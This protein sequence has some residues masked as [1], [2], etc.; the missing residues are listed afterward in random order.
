MEA[1]RKRQA[2]L[3][4]LL[5]ALAG[6]C[7][8]GCAE[9]AGLNPYYRRQWAEDERFGPTYHT[10]L[11]QIR[12]IEGN[13]AGFDPVK[14]QQVAAELTR[15]IQEDRNTV[16]RVAAI[17]SLAA[18]PVSLSE[19]GLQ[20]A[21]TDV[22]PE[23]RMAACQALASSGN[24][25]AASILSGLVESDPDLDVRLAATRGLAGSSDPNSL[26]ALG[27][28]LNDSNPA[29]QYRA[30]QSLKSSTGYRYGDDIALWKAWMRG[31]SPP[32]PSPSIAERLLPVWRR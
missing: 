9:F 25:N 24:P 27:I 12:A 15:L 14:Q 20:L 31:E 1:Q 13:A 18:F 8:S 17:R 26:R 4:G 16:L 5:L 29:L 10:Y 30:V 2:A 23:I 3:F 11:E 32:E 6:L 28:A 22:D 19:Q 7:G 21:I